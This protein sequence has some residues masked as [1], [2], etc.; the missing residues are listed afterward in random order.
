MIALFVSA[1]AVFL[2]FLFLKDE[3]G[4][5]TMPSALKLVFY[6]N[7]LLI[8]GI[9]FYK[10]NQV[11]TIYSSVNIENYR[12]C[13]DKV[14]T[15]QVVDSIDEIKIT[16]FFSSSSHNDAV[17]QKDQDRNS[18]LSLTIRSPKG[19][20]YDVRN[21]TSDDSINKMAGVLKVYPTE[22]G[23][24][25]QAIYA[26]TSV[27]PFVP[28]L[29]SKEHSG[30]VNIE[31]PVLSKTSK[32]TNDYEVSGMMR[33]EAPSGENVLLTE[34]F[35]PTGLLKYHSKSSELIACHNLKI[36][37]DLIVN[38]SIEG[39]IFDFFTA[40]D[41]SQYIYNIGIFTP[42]HVN[43]LSAEYD[44]PI[45]VND[46][47]LGIHAGTFGFTIYGR[48]L[49][50]IQNG[51][52]MNIYVKLP[53][54]ANVQMVRSFIL[55]TLLAALFA[56]FISS[57]SDFIVYYKHKGKNYLVAQIVNKEEKKGAL[58]KMSKEKRL[59]LIVRNILLLMLTCSVGWIAYRI[60]IDEPFVMTE[61][62][63]SELIT[64]IILISILCIFFL[65]FSYYRYMKKMLASKN[66]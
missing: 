27:I 39:C 18:S 47:D 24:M 44:I 40:A 48:Q 51:G 57:L 54:M 5:E 14:N 26:S 32:R 43:Y 55:T 35:T 62:G 3:N 16:N 50:R 15:Q 11:I 38:E 53:T 25:Y 41:V 19:F 10:T 9:F 1:A 58:A 34:Y 7:L 60:Y 4:K 13:F 29:I 2:G 30:D 65:L 6:F 20:A 17:R 64:R 28:V 36:N 31:G 52:N 63:Y 59:F 33:L 46:D 66:H 23:R 8:V 21:A 22:I 45:E 37:T 61:Q 42:C 49:K 12:S 56:L